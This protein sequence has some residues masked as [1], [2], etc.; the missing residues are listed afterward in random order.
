MRDD[1]ITIMSTKKADRLKK[2]SDV[3]QTLR[4]KGIKLI[5]P[6]N[7]F[8]NE[9]VVIEVYTNTLTKEELAAIKEVLD[10]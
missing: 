10:L 6:N 2:E 5:V 7:D 3:V 8:S 9:H 4:N 1:D